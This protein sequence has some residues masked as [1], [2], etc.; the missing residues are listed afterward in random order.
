MPRRAVTSLTVWVTMVTT[1]SPSISP[2]VAP[3]V[4]GHSI[5]WAHALGVMA[6]S[7]VQTSKV[8]T[9][10]SLSLKISVSTTVFLS[11]PL[12]HL[13][14][15]TA[16]V[17]MTDSPWKVGN[18]CSNLCLMVINIASMLPLVMTIK[19][20]SAILH[21]MF[22]TNLKSNSNTFGRFLTLLRSTP[23]LIS[24]S[25]MAVEN[26]PKA[27]QENIRITGMALQEASSI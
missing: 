15:T 18:K 13:N 6:T 12:V 9:I 1:N 3:R 22:I 4:V 16:A 7:K 26:R 21:R 14:G 19:V 5:C 8:G 24:L 27:Q 11:P 20:V 25:D 23:W 10:S 2:L 17:L